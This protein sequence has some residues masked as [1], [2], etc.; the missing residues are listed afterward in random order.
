MIELVEKIGYNVETTTKFISEHNQKNFTLLDNKF[1]N[2]FITC[3]YNCG[4][5]H[6]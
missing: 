2:F 6:I 5:Y 4:I 1:R 3:C